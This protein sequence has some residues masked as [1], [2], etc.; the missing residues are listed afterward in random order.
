MCS[1]YRGWELRK[2]HERDKNLN[3]GAVSLKL[4][5]AKKLGKVFDITNRFSSLTNQPAFHGNT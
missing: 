5:W 1:G 4:V 2:P 3:A